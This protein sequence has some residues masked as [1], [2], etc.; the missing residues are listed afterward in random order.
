[1]GTTSRAY[2]SPATPTSDDSSC[3]VVAHH[4]NLMD[5]SAGAIG[6]A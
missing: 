4:Q 5:I 2:E 1:V 6:G 3:H